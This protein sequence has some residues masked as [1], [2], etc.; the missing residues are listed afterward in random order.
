MVNVTIHLNRSYGLGVILMNR[1]EV[2]KAITKKLQERKKG[3][4]NL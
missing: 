4:V 1:E 3:V 2:E